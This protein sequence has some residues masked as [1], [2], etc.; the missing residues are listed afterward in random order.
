[1]R[2]NNEM[3]G[4][5]GYQSKAS[6]G[7]TPTMRGCSCGNTASVLD[8]RG[9]YQSAIPT[10]NQNDGSAQRSGDALAS[11]CAGN[12]SLAMVYSPKQ[13]FIDLY[14]TDEALSRGTLFAELDKPWYPGGAK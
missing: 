11:A 7:M 1:M 4:C 6:G 8:R 2:Y 5:R 3:N 10:C 12:P 13:A 9:A 14:D